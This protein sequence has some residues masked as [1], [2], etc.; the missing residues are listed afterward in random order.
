MAN[1]LHVF[2]AFNC[3]AFINFGLKS[4]HHVVGKT[5]LFQS[6]NYARTGVTLKSEGD[7]F[8]L[9]RLKGV[10]VGRTFFYVKPRARI[11]RFLPHWDDEQLEAVVSIFKAQGLL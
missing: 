3:A 5:F 1:T 4:S 9:V 11:T 10:G 2:I 7:A 8:A 6:K